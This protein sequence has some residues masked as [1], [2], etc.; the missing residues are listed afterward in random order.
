MRLI[1]KVALAEA[2]E[3]Y[4]Q[5]MESNAQLENEKSDLMDQVHKLQG[6]VQQLEEELSGICR[7]CEEITESRKCALYLN[8][9]V[10]RK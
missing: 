6:R 10:I 8:P 1:V 7:K 5:A 2:V 4:N 9:P 3:K